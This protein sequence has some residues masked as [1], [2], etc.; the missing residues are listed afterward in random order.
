[1]YVMLWSSHNNLHIGMLDNDKILQYK[2][3]MSEYINYTVGV[4]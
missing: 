1:M 4:I 3:K 2:Q